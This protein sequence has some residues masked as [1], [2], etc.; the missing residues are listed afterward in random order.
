MFPHLAQ[1]KSQSP[2]D[3]VKDSPHPTLSPP[4]C[5]LE[6]SH[7][8]PPGA[9]GATPRGSPQGLCT[10]SRLR[11]GCSPQLPAGLAPLEPVLKR[12]SNPPPVP[13]AAPLFPFLF[14]LESRWA[15]YIETWPVRLHFPVRRHDTAHGSPLLLLCRSSQ[16][17]FL[18]AHSL[19]LVCLKLRQ[20]TKGSP[21]NRRAAPQVSQARLH[22]PAQRWPGASPRSFPCRRLS[23]SPHAVGLTRRL[24]VHFAASTRV[25]FHGC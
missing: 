10:A 22:R 6:T 20:L 14:L 17:C 1:P 11:L 2:S 13:W 7:P 21:P 25:I 18:W 23:R 12:V 3:A 5:S 19:F 24:C 4:R 15:F 8:D 9:P 16:A